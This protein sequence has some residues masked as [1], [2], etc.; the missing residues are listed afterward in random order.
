MKVVLLQPP[1]QDFY[2]TEVRLQP[3][4]LCALKAAVQLHL[5]GVEVRVRDYRQGWGRRTVKLPAE[6]ADLRAYYPVPDRS[7]FSTFHN[8]YHFGAGF[9]A[10]AEEVAREQPDLVGIS[11]LF[12]AYHQEVLRCTEAIKARIDVPV[13][14]GG[15]HASAAPE[16][17]LAHP[18]IDF[19]IR[20][21]GERPLVELLRALGNG[22]E[23]ADVPNLVYRCGKNHVLNPL[24]EN[25]PLA[26]LPPPDFSD[27]P[28]ARYRFGRRPLASLIAS[29]GCPHRCRFC[30]MHG[31]FGNGYHRRP[32][33]SILAEI[34]LR[35]A[36]GYRA[37]DF[38]DD[39]LTLA[40]S[41]MEALCR[42][43]IGEYPEGELALQAMNGV[44]YLSLDPEL[45]GLMKRA[46]FS[47]LNLSLVSLDETI[48]RAM[49]RPH[50]VD[51]Y[52]R[53]VH[54]AFRLGFRLVTYQILGLPGESLGSMIETLA[55]SARLPVL[56]GASPFYLPPGAP[57]AEGTGEMDRERLVRCRL[58]AL[59][60]EA[61]DEIYTL[62][63][64]TRIL[65]FLKGLPLD[66]G[67]E[68]S[69]G[70]ALEVACGLGERE[71]LG[72]EILVRVFREGILCAAA[73]GGLEPLP[74]FRSGLFRSLWERL[75]Y[76]A[77]QTGATIRIGAAEGSSS[78]SASLQ[79]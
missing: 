9:E 63:V 78:A 20:G 60:L 71:A 53:I 38:E 54:E 59:G 49:G 34:R 23:L 29:R 19:V 22:G 35:H 39:N 28:V 62:F 58:T 8:Y 51:T 44:S 65:N 14:V 13:V 41:E 42:G 70:E 5:P 25:Y 30:S 45:L 73:P 55:F 17:L 79:R 48:C 61:R 77:T 1:V 7:P 40:R 72:V 16:T 15:A 10:L 57:L 64:A 4:G 37:L 12:S 18:A 67:A 36:Q 69:L 24:A 26:E 46:G 75:H 31:A 47:H 33:E 32:V 52:L 76:I 21:E 66:A 74:R 3:L 68:V 2:D 11:S 43:I 6:L 50:S 56:L 27:L